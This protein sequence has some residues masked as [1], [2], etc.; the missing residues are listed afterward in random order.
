MRDFESVYIA[1]EKT[2]REN[3]SGPITA[4]NWM[5]GE[6]LINQLTSASVLSNCSTPTLPFH[7]AAN[8]WHFQK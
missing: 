7:C 6:S 1:N 5:S 8:L 2:D 4:M 3:I